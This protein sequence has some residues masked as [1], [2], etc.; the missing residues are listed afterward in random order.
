MSLANAAM[1]SAS[2][3]FQAATTALA[4][5]PGMTRRLT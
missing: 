4:V 2:P 3:A 5:R 1:I